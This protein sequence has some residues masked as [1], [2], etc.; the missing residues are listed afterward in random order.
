MDINY[1]L[2]REQISLM[3]AEVAGSVE[4]RIAHE[5]LAR[6]YGARLRQS[7]YPHVDMPV[8]ARKS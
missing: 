7:A 8:V 4:A 6:G 5:G 3:R 1:L 2:K